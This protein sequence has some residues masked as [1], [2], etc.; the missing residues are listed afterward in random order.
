[1]PTILFYVKVATKNA[2]FVLTMLFVLFFTYNVYP[3]LQTAVNTFV[4]FYV[5]SMIGFHL[6]LITIATYVMQRNESDVLRYLERNPVK[7][8]FQFLAASMIV[9]LAVALVPV[10]LMVL[11]TN[12]LTSPAFLW[13]EIAH[14]VIIWLLSSLLAAVIGSSVSML[15]KSKF[16]YVVSLVIYGLFVW[17]SFQLPTT[18]LHRYMN[19]FDNNMYLR[20]NHLS[21]VLWNVDYV[22]DKIFLLLIVVLLLSFVAFSVS[23][24]SKGKWTGLV[25]FVVALVSLWLLPSFSPIAPVSSKADSTGAD[26]VPYSIET[27][28]MDVTLTNTLRNTATL[29][30]HVTEPT[31]A[32]RLRL[33][34]VFSIE[35]VDVNGE[36]VSFTHEDGILDLAVKRDVGEPLV[37]TV[38]YEGV[39][40]LID[41]IGFSTY[42]VTKRAINLP[43]V[44]FDWYPT[45]ESND[46]IH[47]EVDVH[48]SA[49]LYSNLDSSEPGHWS[50]VAT[51]VNVFAGQYES[52]HSDG[53]TFIIPT[54]VR[55]DA[56]IARFQSFVDETIKKGRFTER[57]RSILEEKTYERV[58]VAIWPFQ[59]NEHLIEIVGDTMFVYYDE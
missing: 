52:F 39:V 27:Y 55:P 15:V 2:L 16:A 41:S 47:F 56:F 32:V 6:F 42:Y 44:Y 21:G 19:P 43:G 1:M 14:F 4:S 12:S 54:S 34:D 40:E 8:Q 50:G 22:Y 3:S 53:V 28:E 30:F 11:L 59:A 17:M 29:T 20:P 38:Q 26:H 33:D 51:S 13:K 5:F 25:T 31:E 37:V 35:E 46:P 18:P 23:V 45:V 10:T 57:E 49:P 9:S 7:K 36:K 48:S 58:I 24:S